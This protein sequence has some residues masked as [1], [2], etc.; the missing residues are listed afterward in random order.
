MDLHPSLDALGIEDLDGLTS[1][2]LEDKIH[3]ANPDK[4][5]RYAVLQLLMGWLHEQIRKDIHEKSLLSDFVGLLLN[6]DK[7]QREPFDESEVDKAFKEWQIKNAAE[8]TANQR[9][10]QMVEL[11]I[12][13]LF[14]QAKRG[15]D[16]QHDSPSLELP[17]PVEEEG[18]DPLAPLDQPIDAHGLR[19]ASKIEWRSLRLLGGRQKT[20]ANEVPLG[21]PKRVRGIDKP[22][23]TEIKDENDEGA[24]TKRLAKDAIPIEQTM[25]LNLRDYDSAETPEAVVK[26]SPDKIPISMFS[27]SP[28]KGYVCKRCDRPGHWI[29]LCP[30]NLDPSW[31]KPPAPNY[32]CEICGAKGEHFATLCPQNKKE[33][34][35][36]RQRQRAAGRSRTPTR[37]DG[38]HYRG[39]RSPLRRRS[40]SPVIRSRRK[41][42]DI[43][44]PDDS[45]RDWNEDFG[46]RSRSPVDRDDVSPWTTRERLTREWQHFRESPPRYAPDKYRPRGG[47][48]TPP[49]RHRH[50]A[51]DIQRSPD[52]LPRLRG[53]EDRAREGRL[54][55]DDD[56][57]MDSDH[58]PQTPKQRAPTKVRKANE[59]DNQDEVMEDV[60]PDVDD[61]PEEV[62]RAKREANE[63]LSALAIELF[64]D[65][66][67][68]RSTGESVVTNG[69][70]GESDDEMSVDEC[71]D[72]ISDTA[73]DNSSSP[74]IPDRVV[75]EPRFQPEVVSLFRNYPNPIVNSRTSRKSAC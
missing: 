72:G 48:P 52:P 70:V 55:Y 9:I 3:C 18:E 26:D 67:R 10:Y 57:Y 31:D 50:R 46:W 20:G 53:V 40:R 17:S 28:P 15:L 61:T 56:V 12:H 8:Y 21:K 24:S 27:H 49:H 38:R 29:Q 16:P 32:R 59:D 51:R 43:Y 1:K 36:T 14:R 71:N 63:F 19:D 58:S 13:E 66:T 33:V 65:R 45:W 44:R 75:R 37:D 6:G 42:Y 68:S 74:Q 62:E 34:S 5:P 73:K 54:A 47:S 7:V 35:L 60:S 22:E 4:L 2:E 11:E 39:R 25:K 23:A 64:S 69:G 30:T 41:G